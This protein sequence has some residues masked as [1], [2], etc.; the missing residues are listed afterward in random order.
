M[1]KRYFL[2][3]LLCLQGCA[4]TPREPDFKQKHPIHDIV[5]N[6]PDQEQRYFSEDSGSGEFLGYERGTNRAIYGNRP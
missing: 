4:T 1:T 5:N 6:S 3:L 2:I